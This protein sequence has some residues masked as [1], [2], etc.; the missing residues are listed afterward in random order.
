MKY[1][2]RRTLAVA[3]TVCASGFASLSHAALLSE[4]FN[5]VGTLAGS[6][7]ITTNLSTPGGSTGWY[8][9]ETSVFSAQAGPADSYI[10]ANYNNAPVSGAIQNWLITPSFTFDYFA[11]LSF[12][13]RSD[14]NP[15]F[16]DR[17]Q[18]R[19][20]ATGSSN[21]A[22]FTQVL[23][24]I[25]PSETPGS[26]FDVFTE[27]NALIGGSGGTGRVAFVYTSSN[28]DHANYIGIDTVSVTAVPVTDSL[29]LSALGLGLLG[30]AGRRCQTRLAA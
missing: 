14:G 23:M 22:A 24:D 29:A 5:N 21:T 6:G 12:W 20:S 15:D 18:V 19:Y 30:V 16:G 11:Q 10:A 9:G 8:Q 1:S 26:F 4:G 3:L 2:L 25:N 17:L 27:L 13:T 28:A 7:W